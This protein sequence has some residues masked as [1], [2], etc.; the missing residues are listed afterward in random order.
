M[1]AT[2]QWFRTHLTT[3]PVTLLRVFAYPPHWPGV[4]GVAEHTDYGLLTILMQD[5]CGGR[6]IRSTN[7]SVFDF[8]GTYGQY[9]TAK[10]ARVFP[11]LFDGFKH[12]VTDDSAS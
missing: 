5:D 6:Q 2:P 1:A 12:T 4:W 8:D 10:V 11:V 7:A 9:L 3:D